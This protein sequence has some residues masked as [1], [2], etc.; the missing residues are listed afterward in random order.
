MATQVLTVGAISSS[1]TYALTNAQVSDVLNWFILDWAGPVPEGLTV[2]AQNQWKLDQAN[3]KLRDYMRAESQRNRRRMLVE[4][5][6]S[7]DVQADAET[8]L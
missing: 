5:Q 4:A 8:A 3:A 2:A 6:A 1:I 7:V